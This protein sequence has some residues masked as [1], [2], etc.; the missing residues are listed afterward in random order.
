M[1]YQAL[2]FCPDEK[3][4]RVVSQVFAELDFSIEQVQE[5]FGAVKRL[6]AQ[7]YDAVVVDCENEPNATLLFRSARNSSVNQSS[8]A[9][10]VVEGQAGVAKAYRIGANLVLTKPINVDHAKG[11]LR[12]A[13][14]LLRKN[15]DAAATATNVNPPAAPTTPVT[16]TAPLASTPVSRGVEPVVA[17]ACQSAPPAFETPLPAMAASAKVEK[18]PVAAPAHEVQSK[19]PLTA[20][21]SAEGQTQTAPEQAN[22]HAAPATSKAT[23]SPAASFTVGQ[24]AGAAPA[25][26]RETPA[27]KK[28]VEFEAAYQ[29]D[30]SSST[31]GSATVVDGP[32]FA[33]LDQE[34]GGGSRG[35]RKILVAAAAVLALASVGYVGWNKLSTPKTTGT[36]PALSQPQPPSPPAA[37]ATTPMPAPVTIP[38]TD[39]A[40]ANT[41]T[42]TSK[43]AVAP[44]TAPAA[45]GSSPVLRIDANSKPET[46]HLDVT[47][48]VVKSTPAKQASARTEEAAQLPSP[49]ALGASNDSALSSLT[50]AS[51]RSQPSLAKVNISQGVSQ[52]LLIRRVQPRYPQNAL[53]MHLQGAVQLDA[54]IDKEGKIVNMKVLKGDAVLARAAMDA[55]RQWR[56]KPYYLDGVPV[57]IETQITVNFKLPN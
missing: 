49:L 4:A 24:G 51:F 36:S 18:S 16:A 32:S 55:V 11:T 29:K 42:E 50:A 9:I 53:A 2:L 37:A 39:R 43:T 31:F 54:M 5:P 48:I 22:P 6:M 34:N 23:E 27:E 12:V 44:A 25:P 26:A 20:Q 17:P 28:T 46:K 56:Y 47:R 13:R 8:L 1:G 33:A 10:A 30:N 57:D 40:A 14:G 45:A 19:P 21:P 15:S 7:R 38:A 3:L 41:S 35:S 52:G